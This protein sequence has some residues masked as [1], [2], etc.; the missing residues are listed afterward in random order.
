MEDLAPIA[1]REKVQGAGAPL[2]SPPWSRSLSVNLQDTSFKTSAQ[3]ILSPELLQTQ[4]EL[5]R[6]SWTSAWVQ[7]IST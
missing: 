2:F 4:Q 1:L 5:C 3:T 7:E 6:P